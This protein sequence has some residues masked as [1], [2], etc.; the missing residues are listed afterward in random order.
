M[1]EVRLQYV[2]RLPRYLANELI[3]VVEVTPIHLGV[4]VARTFDLDTNA[5]SFLS[6]RDRLMVMLDTNNF[7]NRNTLN[8]RLIKVEYQHVDSY[9]LAGNAQR[10]SGTHEAINDVDSDNDRIGPIEYVLR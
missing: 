1:L 9:P 6:L 8:E 7:S 2:D 4:V 3:V 5:L 10:R